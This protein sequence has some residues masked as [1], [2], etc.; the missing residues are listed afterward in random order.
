[1]IPAL[2]AL[3]LLVV[4][5]L[6]LRLHPDGGNRPALA[7]V[8]AGVP[9]AVSLWLQQGALAAAL[10]VPV[11]LVGVTAALLAARS[12]LLRRPGLLDVVW[13]AAPAYLVVGE[14]WLVAD[15]LA[16]E[17][18]GVTP[19][20]VILT[21]VH[22]HYAGFAATLLAALAWRCARARSPRAAATAIV[23]LTVAP[24]VVA[25]GFTLAGALQI[26]GAVLL[27][28]GIVALSVV[29]LRVIVGAA[30]GLARPLLT[31][32]A[33]APLLPMVLAVQWAVGWNLGTP[34]LSIPQMAATH[35]LVNAVGF[36]LL[37][38]VGWTA[39]GAAGD[40]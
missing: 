36:V 12:W 1:M 2:L 17:P 9:A 34:A 8:V 33:V 39:I 30:Q 22:F 20:F 11:V 24:P 14:I 3:G 40:R 28:A 29:M 37:G 21:A 25:A 7:A 26:V 16:V 38:L 4:V 5:P 10:A 31:V 35:G 27:T 32:S 6:G 13:V 23:L 19:P 18:A 15:R